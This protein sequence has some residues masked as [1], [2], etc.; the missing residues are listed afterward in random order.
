MSFRRF[1]IFGMLTSGSLFGFIALALVIADEARMP[2]GV[3]V[4]LS[5]IAN[6]SGLV[7]AILEFP[8]YKRINQ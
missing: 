8:I 1:A 7:T 3:F 2:I 6:F 4:A 5:V